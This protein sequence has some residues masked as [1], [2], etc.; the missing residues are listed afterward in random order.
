[1]SNYEK[2]SALGFEVKT[3]GRCGGSGRYSFNMMDGDR[4][5]GCSGSGIKYTKRGAAAR[6]KMVELQTRDLADLKP[7]MFY[8]SSAT[9]KFRQ[10][11]S[12]EQSGSC[13][14]YGDRKEYFIDIELKSGKY[15]VLPSSKVRFVRDEADRLETVAAALAYQD[16]LTAMGKPK[17]R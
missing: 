3:C 5:Y 4:C 1:M 8:A 13:A 6:A 14:I 9:A 12:V 2:V 7:G 17:K 10:V 15:G 11:L 16:T